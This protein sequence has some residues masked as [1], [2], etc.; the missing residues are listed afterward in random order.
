MLRSYPIDIDG[1]FVGAAVQNERGFR[2]IA[3]DYRLEDL[4]QTVWPT[5]VDVRRLARRLFLNGRLDGQVK[6]A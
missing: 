3:T 2:F 5:V 1:V 6:A 4:D